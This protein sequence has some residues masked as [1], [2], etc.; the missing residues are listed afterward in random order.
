MT[1]N[2]LIIRNVKKNFKHYY[3]YI[4]ALV[5]SVGLYFSFVTLQYDPA[6][7]ETKG[8]LKGAAAFKSGS[9]LLIIIVSVFLLYANTLF[10][11]RRGKEIGLFQLIGMTK[12]TIFRI[13]SVENLILYVSSLVMGV[14]LGFSMSRL[15]M[16][17]LFNVTGVEDVATLRFSQEALFQTVIVFSAIYLLI[18]VMNYIFIRKQSILSLF[19]V[20]STTQ[21]RVQKMTAFQAVIGVL[22][23]VFIVFGYYLSSKL[24]SSMFFGNYLFIVMITILGSVIVG[25][26]LFYKGSVS[27]IFN[28]IRKRKGGYLN[29]NDVLSLSSIMFRMKSNS[30]LL[31][32]ITTLSA[33]AI[34]L[35]SLSY[36][37]YYSAEKGSEKNIPHHFAIP[38]T[39][40]AKQFTD[41]L[42]QDGISYTETSIDLLESK[43]NLAGVLSIP[44][45]DN[46]LQSS[47][48]LENT[49]MI[50]ISDE[51]VPQLDVAETDVIFV[52]QHEFTKKLLNFQDNGEI[53][54]SGGKASH[55]LKFKGSKDF[56]VIPTR[57]T[58]A[59][60]VA[61]VDQKVFQQMMADKDP[62]IK[63]EFT[64]YIGV[65]I[66]EGREIER[67]DSIFKETEVNI[68]AAHESR[69]EES[70][71]Q[72]QLMGLT[73][74]I[75][76]FLGLAFLITSGCIL[77]FKQMDESEDEKSNYTVL[78]KIGFTQADLLKGIQRKQ[79]FNFGI[80]LV[81]GLC[82]SYFA[83]KS[84]WF[85]FG[86]ELLTPMI[87]VMLIYTAL[88]SI[89]GVL[90]VL[91][92]KRVIKEAL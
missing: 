68:W 9:V 27:F 78:R 58:G 50:V 37:S 15:L 32:V 44:A 21:Q 88:Y 90:S 5:F 55:A 83:V 80:P 82:H 61:V 52:N 1:L 14:F 64:E 13:L 8:S 31:T 23:I 73:M 71:K 42:E 43:V 12:G 17:I 33:L 62:S 41:A 85:F 87:I 69:F 63:P 25:T 45:G 46:D 79:L 38:N 2:Q 26:Y 7:N 16:L 67:A 47:F 39:E 34:G 48:D 54:F 89:F 65:M 11:K 51:V 57:L 35:L 4:F 53:V 66:E 74:F 84:G 92:Y 59:F 28:L 70:M 19:R 20:T 91:N 18:L 40:H 56:S 29:V 22:G 10:I 86:T 76:G 49:S 6:L 72:K 77:Y 30:F 3:V 60:P 75:V 36:I 24:F 81:V